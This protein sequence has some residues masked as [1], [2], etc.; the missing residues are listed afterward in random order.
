MIGL[1][2]LIIFKVYFNFVLQ[3]PFNYA[4]SHKYKSIFLFFN[5]LNWAIFFSFLTPFNPKI[6]YSTLGDT[7]D[8]ICF[9]SLFYLNMVLLSLF[10][11]EDVLREV[12]Q[13]EKVDQLN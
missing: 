13:Q 1:L 3:K 2:S 9:I 5:F 4:I 7:A 10:G 11:Q 8:K 12:M 6:A